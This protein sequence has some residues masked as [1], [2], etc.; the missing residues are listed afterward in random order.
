[1]ITAQQ[2]TMANP[3]ARQELLDGWEQERLAKARVLIAGVGALGNACAATLALTGVGRFVLVDFDTIETSN[4]S[5]TVLF[6]S[7]DE[8]RPK[9]EVAAARLREL[10]L[11]DNPCIVP[12]HADVVW[13]LGW[14][15]LR[16]VDIVLGCV[17]SAEARAWVGTPAWGLGVPAIF[18]G[19]YGFNCGVMVQGVG[20]GPC[21][22]CSFGQGE[23]GDL[24]RRYSCDQVR[25]AYAAEAKMPATQVAAAMAAAVMAK[26]SCDILHG[27][28]AALGMRLVHTGR[29]PRLE[30]G[31]VQRVPRCPFHWQIGAVQE[32]PELS[33]RLTAGAVVERLATLLGGEVTIELGRDFL[34]TSRCKGCGEELRLWRPRHQVFEQ[35]LVCAGCQVA[36][37]PLLVDPQV[38]R[39]RTV[40]AQTAPEVLDLTLA[41]LGVPPLHVL[42]V[43]SASGPGWVELSGDMP[44]VLPNW[45][46][47]ASHQR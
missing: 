32:L 18:G 21:I 43:Q 22:A 28:T 23:W 24:G 4:L 6:R 7:G 42:E 19:I 13:G 33:C 16:R 35:E 27:K 12:L 10:V 25:R 41:E 14:G 26:E 30:W 20:D 36:D 31:A 8:G 3:F 29:W 17:D 39:V 37:R 9:V 40:S 34:L 45:P 44:A 46:S 38:V 2:Q 15:V 11:A 47:H 1:M 5:R